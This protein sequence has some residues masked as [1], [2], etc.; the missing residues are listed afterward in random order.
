MAILGVGQAELVAG[1]GFKQPYVSDVMRGRFKGIT[2]ENAQRFADFFGCQIE[3]LFPPKRDT[4]QRAL[5]F[6][7]AESAV[8]Q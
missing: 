5:D 3:D 2:V 1:T 6:P 7:S 4:R 8:A